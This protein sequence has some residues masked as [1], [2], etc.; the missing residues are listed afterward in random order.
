V[1]PARRLGDVLLTRGIASKVE[2]ESDGSATVWV[3]EEAEVERAKGISAEFAAD[4]DGVATREV[5]AQADRLRRET[6][7]PPPVARPIRVT[8][9][10]LGAPGIGPVTMSLIGLSI[11]ASIATNLGENLEVWTWLA[12]S[13]LRSSFGP[14]AGFG[15]I[16]HGQIWRI[17]TPMFVHMSI[18]HI[19]F[20]MLWLRDLGAATETVRGSRF[21]LLLVLFIAAVS[22]TAQ[23][24]W[25]GPF[26]GGMSG[27]GY[28][29]F[30]YI[31]VTTRRDPLAGFMLG[32]QTV[33]LMIGWLVL[34]FTGLMGPVANTAHVVGMLAGMAAAWVLTIRRR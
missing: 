28:G 34:C 2:D 16:L 3:I 14:D 17:F 9:R 30:G 32:Q 20:N 13:D 27:V 24:L 29:L 18:F 10:T 21:A 1:D 12:Y 25:N 23:Y 7:K 4:P 11:A 33:V 31:W 6:R 22:N 19:L 8:R 5:L 15:A 26:F